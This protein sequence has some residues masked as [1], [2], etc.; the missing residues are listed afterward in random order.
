M[1]NFQDSYEH[2]DSK[3]EYS[4][5]S[6]ICSD[7]YSSVYEFE[8]CSCESNCLYDN[9]SCLQRSGIKYIFRN[10][11]C[12][13]S[14]RMDINTSGKPIYECN[15]NC[16]CAIKLCGNKLVQCG[17]RSGL[18]IKKF[19]KKG[20]GLITNHLIPSGS[21]VCEYA[22]RIITSDMAKRLY[23]VYMSKYSMNY[24]FCINEK[25]GENI[26]R[27]IIDPTESGNIGRYINHSC[28]PNCELII[29]RI[30]NNFPKLCIFAKEKI[31]IGEELSFNY[32]DT[33]IE[34][35]QSVGQSIECL[36]GKMECK[37]FLPFDKY[38]F[39]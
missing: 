29:V 16:N 20:L 2:M 7:L 12:L 22:G 17:P 4:P 15:R 37:K 33:V 23:P 21:F 19:C 13:E 35:N 36:C 11:E 8:G 24:I 38:C 39:E 27:T 32:G 30:H 3:I 9:C 18:K 25:F 6:I 14:Y 5:E 10:Q 26:Y 1:M 31:N 28:E 34:D